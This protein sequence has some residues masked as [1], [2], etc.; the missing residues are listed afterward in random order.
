MHLILDYDRAIFMMMH[1]L[2]H[3]TKQAIHFEGKEVV[4]MLQH[5]IVIWDWDL[6]NFYNFCMFFSPHSRQL[7]Q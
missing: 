1:L 4:E 2:A 7:L 3:S 5:N 6:G